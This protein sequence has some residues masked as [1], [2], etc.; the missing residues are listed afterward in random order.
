MDSDRLL[1]RQH[2]LRAAVRRRVALSLL[3]RSQIDAL[4]AVPR[5]GGIPRDER[6]QMAARR[7]HSGPL[8]ARAR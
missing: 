2:E 8:Q 4:Q 7:R 1:H 6:M 3:V 5:R